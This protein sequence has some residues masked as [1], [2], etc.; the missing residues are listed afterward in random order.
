M[1]VRRKSLAKH[2]RRELS[3]GKFTRDTVIHKKE[4]SDI[5]QLFINELTN[6]LQHHDDSKLKGDEQKLFEDVLDNAQPA[7]YG[8]SNYNSIKD[9]LKPALILHYGANRHHPEHFI[10]GISGMNLID[11]MEMFIDW[12]AATNR[13][14][15]DDIHKSIDINTNRYHLP[16]EL[17]AIF[18]NTA[19]DFFLGKED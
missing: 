7:E 10:D 16:E 17:N 9:R 4:V 2:I 12:C 6:R 13:H 18:H 15:D 1:P 5:G 14:K 3:M 19:K 11:L 8:T